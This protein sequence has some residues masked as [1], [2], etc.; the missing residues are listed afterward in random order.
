MSSL[1]QVAL[2]RA[3]S[4]EQLFDCLRLGQQSSDLANLQFVTERFI[5]DCREIPSM[6]WDLEIEG[7]HR[8]SHTGVGWF[9]F[10]KQVSAATAGSR[11][12]LSGISE[13]PAFRFVLGRWDFAKHRGSLCFAERSFFETPLMV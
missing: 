9:F 4:R 7:L 1:I 3:P 11:Y 8:G 10:G 13:N 2:Q 5:F 6:I 12:Q